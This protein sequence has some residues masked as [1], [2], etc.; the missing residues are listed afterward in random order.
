MRSFVTTVRQLAPSAV[1]FTH[2]S[3]VIAEVRSSELESGTVTQLVVPLNERAPPEWPAAEAAP[4][5]SATSATTSARRA[6]QK[7]ERLSRAIWWLSFR[8]AGG[9]RAAEAPR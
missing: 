8:E 9:G 1:A 6:G 4:A 2:A 3:T 7:R 5:T